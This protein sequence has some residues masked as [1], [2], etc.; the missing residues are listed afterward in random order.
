MTSSPEG[1]VCL[2][3]KSRSESNAFQDFPIFIVGLI[4]YLTCSGNQEESVLAVTP[5]PVSQPRACPQAM[6]AYQVSLEHKVN[7][8]QGL[9]AA[10]W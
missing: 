9:Q 6:T 2:L 10:A 7:S 1:R 8:G 3:Q 4:T 5:F